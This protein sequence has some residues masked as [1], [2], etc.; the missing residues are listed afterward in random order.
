MSFSACA[1]RY[2]TDRNFYNFSY[3]LMEYFLE[4]ISQDFKLW[5]KNQLLHEQIKSQSSQHEQ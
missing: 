2:C 4:N 3:L 5:Q 1:A